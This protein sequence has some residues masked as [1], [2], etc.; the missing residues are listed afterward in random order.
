[1]SGKK[2]PFAL[3]SVLLLAVFLLSCGN[4]GPEIADTSGEEWRPSN[5]YCMRESEEGPLRRVINRTDPELC[6]RRVRHRPPE[7]VRISPPSREVND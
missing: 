4:N 1:M 3:A 5:G 6:G 7:F 2:I